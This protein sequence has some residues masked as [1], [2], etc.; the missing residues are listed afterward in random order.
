M[1]MTVEP[2]AEHRWLEQLV[3][4]WT[5]DFEMA[6]PDQA[7]EKFVGTESVRSLGGIWVQCEQRGEA[8]GGQGHT[9]LMTLGFDPSKQRFV[10][11]FLG[12][13]MTYLWVYDGELDPTGNKLVLGAVGPDFNVEGKMSQYRDSIE[14]VSPDHR[15]LRSEYADEGGTWHDFMEMHFRRVK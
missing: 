12:S 5:Y 8:P 13:A 9:N 4:E 3:G 7:P 1:S 10:G 6:G 14:F 2:Q 15:V 11:T